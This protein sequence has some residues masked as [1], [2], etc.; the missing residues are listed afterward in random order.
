MR[1][2]LCGILLLLTLAV[3][4][5]S[6]PARA[7]VGTVLFVKGVPAGQFDDAIAS[8]RFNV[9]GTMDFL[10]WDLVGDNSTFLDWPGQSLA[11]A[12]ASGDAPSVLVTGGF[13]GITC[14]TVDINGDLTRVAGSPF[15]GNQPI[16]E[17]VSVAAVVRRSRTFVYGAEMAQN[18]IR[19]FEVQGNGTLVELPTSPFSTAD[20]VFNLSAGDTYLY[21]TGQR[22]QKEGTISAYRVSLD[23]QLT[24]PDGSPYYPGSTALSQ[25][26]VDPTGHFVFCGDR[27]Q[28]RVYNYKVNRGSTM[29]SALTAIVP[30]GS[31]T[32][33]FTPSRGIVLGYT[34]LLFALSDASK[35]PILPLR[36][37]AAG[38]LT[39]LAIP[40]LPGTHR[41]THGALDPGESYLV[42]N[43]DFGGCLS[44][45]AIDRA[46][47]RLI[48]IKDVFTS[49]NYVGGV[50]FAQP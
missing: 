7:A 30:R 1:R 29:G 18:R 31:L 26:V 16:S 21:A 39:P 20:A 3:T 42:V 10:A 4:A 45:L 46:T 2:L 49:L 34:D 22:L 9:D 33:S 25:A 13:Q 19:G 27:F 8:Y 12:R 14:F 38:V 15:Q 28:G 40:A 47:G 37:D 36:R 24:Q 43:D 5:G 11:Y 35:N 50:L 41:L 44:S 6:R 23:G 48:P 32:G 17:I